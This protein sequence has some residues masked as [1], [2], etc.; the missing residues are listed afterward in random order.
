MSNN[1]EEILKSKSFNSWQLLEDQRQKLDQQGFC[2]IEPNQLFGKWIKKDI[3]KIRSIIDELFKKE[4]I[5][6][7]SEGKEEFTILKNK[8]IENGANRLGNLL[9]KNSIFAKIATLP[10][11]INAT[12]HIIKSEIKLSSILFREPE[13]NGKEQ[14]IHIDWHA[15]RNNNDSYESVVS[16]FYLDAATKRNGATIVIPGS[17][18]K[19]GYPCEHI[20]PNKKHPDE[21]VIEAPQGSL[22]ILNANTWHKGGNNFSGE[23]EE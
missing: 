23:K 7:G 12:Y 5:T 10:I 19:L 21:L 22:L 9:N 18:K 15:R 3:S 14:E 17:H 13:K 20:N 4:G 8:K 16:F 1:F 2:L 11:L 6:A